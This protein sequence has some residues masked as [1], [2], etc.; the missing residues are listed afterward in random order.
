[1]VCSKR[2]EPCSADRKP[3]PGQSACR[4]AR[5]ERPWPC[6]PGRTRR[7]LQCLPSCRS[8][9]G[10]VVRLA[11]L[12]IPL[13]AN[14]RAARNWITQVPPQL[15]AMET[16]HRLDRKWRLPPYLRHVEGVHCQVPATPRIRGV[17]QQVVRVRDRHDP[18]GRRRLLGLVMA[19]P[20]LQRRRQRLLE[21]ANPRIA[22]LCRHELD[23][24]RY[25]V[26]QAAST[27]AHVATTM[28]FAKRAPA[29]DMS[30]MAF[31]PPVRRHQRSAFIRDAWQQHP[32]PV[33]RA[34]AAAIA[35]SASRPAA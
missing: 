25:G 29:L 3:S 21:P 27:A 28:P 12:G 31:L 15:Q 1:M 17:R 19:K 6:A 9:T 11:P 5:P 24:V 18:Q 30:R 7:R 4:F 26:V 8:A 23:L 33:G 20:P 13:C 10:C 22:N 34:R 14:V 32:Q 35:A 16:Q 2:I